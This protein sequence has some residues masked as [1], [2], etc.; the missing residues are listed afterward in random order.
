MWLSRVP[1]SKFKANWSRGSWVLIGQRNKKNKHP[2][3]SDGIHKTELSNILWIYVDMW[4][5]FVY[6]R[7]SMWFI[8]SVNYSNQTW[9]VDIF[10]FCMG[11]TLNER[12]VLN[13]EKNLK[14]SRKKKKNYAQLLAIKF[15]WI[16]EHGPGFFP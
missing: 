6:T 13:Q 16:R 12:T 11:R 14:F 1:L 10:K 2:P 9:V 4:Y 8:G 15:H 7:Q 3:K 5:G